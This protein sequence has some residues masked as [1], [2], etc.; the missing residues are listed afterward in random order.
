MILHLLFIRFY[1]LL[2]YVT[3]CLLLVE[4]RRLFQKILHFDINKPVIGVSVSGS[5]HLV[6]IKGGGFEV[7][8]Y[9][10]EARLQTHRLEVAVTLAE[11]KELKYVNWCYSFEWGTE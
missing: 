4:K 6:G 2:C 1:H 3:F 7:A 10:A 5:C 8:F 11:N 9:L